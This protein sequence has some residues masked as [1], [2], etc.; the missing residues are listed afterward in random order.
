MIIREHQ[1][2]QSEIATLGELIDQTPVEDVID[3]KSLLARKKEVEKAL[4]ALK[5]PYYEPARGQLIFDGKPVIKSHGVYTDF[6]ACAL[7]KYA[8]MISTL[9]SNQTVD[10]GL[11]GPLPNSEEFQLMITGTIL[12]SFGFEIEEVTKQATI[13]PGLSPLKAAMEKANLVMGLPIGS[14]DDDIAEAI[15][16]ISTR[17]IMAI[18][19]FLEVMENHGAVFAVELEDRNKSLKFDEV[20]QI[21][22]IRERIKPENIN[23]DDIDLLGEFEGTVPARRLFQFLTIKPREIIIGKIGL[24]IENPSEINRFLGIPMRIKVHTK[25]VGSSRPRYMLNGYEMIN[26]QL[27]N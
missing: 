27:G 13:S 3:R 22:Q 23:E 11:C 5:S 14:T 8:N 10:L 12:G 2:L 1:L 7:D 4:A 25:Q 6:A 21:I 18:R 16:D 15:A 9:G 24:N 19:A 20:E 17:S 26:K